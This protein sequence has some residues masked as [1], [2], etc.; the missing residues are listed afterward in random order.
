MTV[1][2]IHMSWVRGEG[3]GLGATTQWGGH[4]TQGRAAGQ[5]SRTGNHM[6][7]T[8]THVCIHTVIRQSLMLQQQYIVNGA[9]HE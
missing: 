9:W 8:Y 7:H 2:V 6:A 3:W 5:S 4:N 1:R